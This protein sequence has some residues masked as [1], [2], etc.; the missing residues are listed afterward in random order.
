MKV[1]ALEWECHTRPNQYPRFKAAVMDGKNFMIVN[2]GFGWRLYGF[3]GIPTTP[4]PY[5]TEEEAKSAAQ[6][7]WDAFI[8]SHIEDAP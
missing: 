2:Y 8:L 5:D 3:P 6:K 1:K 4:T 7:L